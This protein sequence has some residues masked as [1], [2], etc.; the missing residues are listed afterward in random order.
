V[1]IATLKVWGRYTNYL[2]K[3]KNQEIP[4]ITDK[5]N[6]GNFPQ[7]IPDKILIGMGIPVDLMN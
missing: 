6:V 3:M 2:T 7:L 5:S 1:S 4:L